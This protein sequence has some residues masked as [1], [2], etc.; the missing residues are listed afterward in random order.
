MQCVLSSGILTRIEFLELELEVLVQFKINKLGIEI[1]NLQ[2]LDRFLILE[3]KPWVSNRI[4][5]FTLFF[6]YNIYSE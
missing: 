1:E 3:P 5:F 2:D 4:N 6:F